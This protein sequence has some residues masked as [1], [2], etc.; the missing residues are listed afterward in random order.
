MLEMD[1][2]EEEIHELFKEEG[3]SELISDML[4][5]GRTVEEIVEFSGCSYEDVKKVEHSILV[6]T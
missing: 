3:K 1:Y 2:D 4:R 5:L 6:A